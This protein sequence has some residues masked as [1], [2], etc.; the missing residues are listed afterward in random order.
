MNPTKKEILNLLSQITK[1]VNELD[2]NQENHIDAT[3]LFSIFM[4][5]VD[6]LKRLND[7]FVKLNTDIKKIKKVM[8]T[9]DKEYGKTENYI[10]TKPLFE[11]L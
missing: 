3:E 5:N 4:V 8:E 1:L 2:E 11:V 9:V 10:V 7:E 6:E